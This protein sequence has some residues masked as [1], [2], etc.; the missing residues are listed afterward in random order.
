MA[1][2]SMDQ[3]LMS[4]ACQPSNDFPSNNDWDVLL[5][6]IVVHEA[7]PKI[8]IMSEM[9]LV[10]GLFSW[11]FYFGVVLCVFESEK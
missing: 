1:P 9:Y 6:T 5:P 4:A 8:S 2:S 10:I 11:L 7:S 3:K